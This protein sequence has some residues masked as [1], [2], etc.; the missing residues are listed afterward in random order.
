MKINI[1][2][3][4]TFLQVL[5]K[6]FGSVRKARPLTNPLTK[7]LTNPLTNP[8][9]KPLTNPPTNPLTNPQTKALTKPLTKFVSNDKRFKYRYGNKC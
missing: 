9:T 7:A 4:Q 5:Q 3:V 1:K 2:Q 6:N 8:L